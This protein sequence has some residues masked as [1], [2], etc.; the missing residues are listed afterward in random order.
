MD[1]SN[2][3]NFTWSNGATAEDLI[4]ITPGTYS[5]TMVD[6][7]GCTAI[8]EFNIVAEFPN[9]DPVITGDNQLC[10]GEIG[11]LDAGSLGRLQSQDVRIQRYP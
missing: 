5:V 7:Y 2:E 3:P 8:E 11:T 1:C 10:I 9:P 4:G 6:G